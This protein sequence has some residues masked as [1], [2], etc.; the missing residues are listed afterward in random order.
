MILSAR[1]SARRSG[2]SLIEVL[3]ALAIFLMCLTVIGQIVDFAG[4][5][6]L[7]AQN[8]NNGSRLASSKMAEVEAGV[9]SVSSG[10]SGDFT[11]DGETGWSWDVT[12]STTEIANVFSVTVT[13]SKPF[14]GQNFQ[15]TLTQTIF[16]PMVMG[17]GAEAQPPAPLSA[18][19][20]M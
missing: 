3:L 18:T 14:Q 15:V 16:D 20:G 19:E 13:V 12:S 2:L 10:G 8:Q 6:A 11:A 7:R 9:I 17:T 4:T 5:N 1:S